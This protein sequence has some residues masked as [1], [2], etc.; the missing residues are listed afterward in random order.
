MDVLSQTIAELDLPHHALILYPAGSTSWHTNELVAV[1]YTSPIGGLLQIDAA[2][3][4]V[5]GTAV[6]DSG[7]SISVANP[8]A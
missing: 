6:I 4:A 8:R 5:H 3:G 7:T 1:P 2:F